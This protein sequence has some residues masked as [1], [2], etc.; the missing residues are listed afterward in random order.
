MNPMLG[1]FLMR[2]VFGA[3]AVLGLEYAVKFVLRVMRLMGG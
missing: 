3:T 2:I 1:E